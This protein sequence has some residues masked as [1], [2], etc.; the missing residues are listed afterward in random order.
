VLIRKSVEIKRKK[1]KEP[2]TK[3]GF[4]KS[5]GEKRRTKR[6]GESREGR[7]CRILQSLNLR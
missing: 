7:A 2:N 1:K 6:R 4:Y 5:L 3:L